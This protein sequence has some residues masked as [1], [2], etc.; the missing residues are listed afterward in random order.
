[1]MIIPIV[2]GAFVTVTKGLLKELEDLEV[3]GRKNIRFEAIQNGVNSNRASDL[4]RNRL[5]NLCKLN[6]ANNVKLNNGL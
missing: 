2:I 1:M 6:S 5:S 3:G 4:N